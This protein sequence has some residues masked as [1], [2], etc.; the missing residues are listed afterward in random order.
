MSKDDDRAKFFYDTASKFTPL[1]YVL[2]V[3]GDALN[4]NTYSATSAFVAT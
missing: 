1:G 2:D 4:A 3:E